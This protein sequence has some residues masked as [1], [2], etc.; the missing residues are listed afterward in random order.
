VLVNDNPVPLYYVSPLQ[1]N[2]QMPIGAPVSGTVDVTVQKRSTGQILGVSPVQM[3]VVSPGIFVSGSGNLRQAAVINEDGSINGPTNAAARGSVIAIYAT[4]QG[5]VP[6]PP[7]DG[8]PSTGLAPTPEKPRVFI[9]PCF[10]DDLGC[11]L[12][13]DDGISYSGLAP[14][15]V[16]IWQINVRIPTATAAGAQRFIFLQ[17]KSVASQDPSVF[18]AVIA[19][20]DP[21]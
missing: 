13:K 19:V 1:I 18:R 7:E 12:D 10:T 11:T 2:I 21:K 20:K 5:P 9:E 6:N 4:G 14:G 15:Q 3:N 17:Y 16:G 8:V